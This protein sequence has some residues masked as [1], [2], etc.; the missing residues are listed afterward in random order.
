MDFAR[1]S[2]VT[3][4]LLPPFLSDMAGRK[5]LLSCAG[6]PHAHWGR[7]SCFSYPRL[8][9]NSSRARTARLRRR[10]LLARSLRSMA[11]RRQRQHCFQLASGGTL[12][13]NIRSFDQ[14]VSTYAGPGVLEKVDAPVAPTAFR[15]TDASAWG[16]RRRGNQVR[17]RP[18]SPLLSDSFPHMMAATSSV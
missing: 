2:T 7:S 11:P 1:S 17:D 3:H 16:F 12:K 14:G 9:G 13:G 4:P 10:S 15:R 8:H 5:S 18:C 6:S